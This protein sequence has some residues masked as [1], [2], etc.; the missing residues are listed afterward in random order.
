MFTCSKRRLL[1]HCVCLTLLGLQLITTGLVI[2]YQV[3]LTGRNGDT[4]DDIKPIKH[5]IFTKWSAKRKLFCNGQLVAYGNTFALL[6]DVLLDR[7]LFISK[8][9]GGEDMSSVINQT[10]AEEYFRCKY[11]AF[12]LPCARLPS[13]YFWSRNHLNQWL[14][15]LDG[16]SGGQLNNRTYLVN[17]RLT[18]A[19]QRYEYVNI[20]H[21]MTDWYNAF[22]LKAF[23][24]RTPDIL[25][26]D[27]HPAGCLDSTWSVL[28]HAAKRLKALPPVTR[29]THL[30]WG[31]RGYDSPLSRFGA[32][33][34]PLVE[35]FRS[36]FLRRF[37]VAD[38]HALN[39][40][41]LNILFIWRRDYVTHP[42]NP[43]GRIMRKIAN[44]G[45]LLNH[46]GRAYPSHHVTGLQ[47]D[48]LSMKQQLT[49]MSSVD[50]LIGMHGAGLTHALF[51]PRRAALIELYPAPYSL[52]HFVS[53]ARW[54]NLIYESWVDED[55]KY[56]VDEGYSTK[57]PP[58][59]LH[60]TL[61]KALQQLCP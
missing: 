22:L 35:E 24:R 5:R 17:S 50:V 3:T 28:F 57:V 32:S 48:K 45:Q 30:V 29:F 37:S 60:S 55:K 34:L 20:Y 33:E 6:K 39:C 14:G 31:I 16:D 10:E 25:F 26:V 61:E 56:L 53:I 38:D 40:H 18:I 7:D 8:N 49:L 27:A 12:W 47:I 59:E 46:I 43:S 41:R 51:L 4:E 54:R 58:N 2:V 44:E 36:F 21:T 9:K 11:G 1:K 23:F 52:A 13:Y 42:R 15:C 19:V